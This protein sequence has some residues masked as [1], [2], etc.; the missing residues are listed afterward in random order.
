MSLQQDNPELPINIDNLTDILDEVTAPDPIFSYTDQNNALELHKT[1]AALKFLSLEK[2]SC[3]RISVIVFFNF[4][5][6]IF[7]DQK[8]IQCC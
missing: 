4:L 8:S 1:R 7:V 6:D 5:I 3:E 2:V